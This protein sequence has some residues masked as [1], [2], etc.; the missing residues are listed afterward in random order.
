MTRGG[1][2]EG[3]GRKSLPEKRTFRGMKAFDDEWALIKAFEKI[4]KKGDKQAA[5]EFIKSNRNI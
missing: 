1:A 4:V 3:A 2:R 5:E